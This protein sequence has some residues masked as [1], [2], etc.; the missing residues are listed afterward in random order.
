MVEETRTQLS[1]GYVLSSTDGTPHAPAAEPSRFGEVLI[2]IYRVLLALAAVG[3][4][5][6]IPSVT[7]PGACS[8]GSHGKVCLFVPCVTVNV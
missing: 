1:G 8:N 4:R 7:N 3:M 2:Q 5:Q 6:V